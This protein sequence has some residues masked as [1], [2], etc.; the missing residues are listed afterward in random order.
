[1]EKINTDLI[2]C[3]KTDRIDFMSTE[4]VPWTLDGEFGGRKTAVT[5]KNEHKAIE[6][7]VKK[8]PS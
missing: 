1:M 6:I 2:Y 7:K 3:F 8:K 4:E 5:I